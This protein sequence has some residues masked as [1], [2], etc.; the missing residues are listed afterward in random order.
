MHHGKLVAVPPHRGSGLQC[1]RLSFSYFVVRKSM[2]CPFVITASKTFS[3]RGFFFRFILTLGQPPEIAL[4]PLVSQPVVLPDQEIEQVRE[5][6]RIIDSGLFKADLE[7]GG[8]PLVKAH[9]DASA[10]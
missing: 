6:H 3:A 2:W 4:D 9:P 1:P 8:E 10:G 5:E 7:V